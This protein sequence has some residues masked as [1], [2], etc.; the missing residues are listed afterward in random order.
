MR[1]LNDMIKGI[2]MPEVL[3]A[4]E[5]LTDAMYDAGLTGQIPVSLPAAFLFCLGK[6][7]GINEERRRRKGGRKHG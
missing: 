6:R 2:T 7:V 3:Q 1:K 5:L 4:E